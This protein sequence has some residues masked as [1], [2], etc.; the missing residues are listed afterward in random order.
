[1]DSKTT[2]IKYPKIRILGHKEN[3]G[4]LAKGNHISIQEKIDGGNFRFMLKQNR[5]IFGSRETLLGDEKI[6]T[7]NAKQFKRCIDHIIDKIDRT[8]L[9]KS[10]KESMIFFGE[11]CIKHTVNYDWN[12]IPP[13]LGFDIYN[14][15]TKR[16]LL[17]SD[18]NKHFELLNLKFVPILAED[19]YPNSPLH[20]LVRKTEFTS[21]YSVDGKAEGIV[22]KNCNRQIYAKI[23]D[24]RFREKNRETFGKSKKFAKDDNE[25]FVC[26]YCTN[27][28]IEKCVFKLI[29]EGNE[30]DMPLMK[31]LPLFVYHDIWNE[32]MLEIILSH[33]KLDLGDVRNK[34]AKR[35]SSVLRQVIINNELNR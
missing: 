17:G 13:F 5:I 27:A 31:I 30:L 26:K 12:K 7:Q 1:M 20:S 10:Y 35:C 19:F 2:F 23:V 25:K 15:K 22:I 18:A 14:L 6:Q 28:R 32:E 9:E 8:V 34:I 21:K 16:F 33:L 3:K 11:N 4:I 29:D 24:E